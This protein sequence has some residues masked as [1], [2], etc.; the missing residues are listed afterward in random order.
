MSI[1]LANIATNEAT[2]KVPVGDEDITIV[3]YPN[4]ITKGVIVQFDDLVNGICQVLPAVVK[5]WDLLDADGSMF[6]LE[7]TR[8]EELGIP[9]LALINKAIAKDIYPKN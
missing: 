3:Y 5:S 4:R 9:L 7:P 8:L 2:V 1:T 6:P